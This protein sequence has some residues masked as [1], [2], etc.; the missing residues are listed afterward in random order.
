MAIKTGIVDEINPYKVMVFSEKTIQEI[1]IRLPGS[2]L[3]GNQ[4]AF[5]PR[6]DVSTFLPFFS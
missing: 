4:L 3:E 1:V 6:R 2:T 5:P